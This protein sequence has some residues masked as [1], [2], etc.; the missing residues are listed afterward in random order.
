MGTFAFVCCNILL[1]F[2][3]VCRSHVCVSIVFLVCL[4]VY[5]FFGESLCAF[6]SVCCKLALHITIECVLH[7]C[8][9]FEC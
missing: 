3:R 2:T 6:D 7:V 4:C 1:Q 5:A 9:V 8:L